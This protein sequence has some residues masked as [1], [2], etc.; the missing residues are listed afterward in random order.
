MSEKVTSTNLGDCP[1]CKA[2]G[3]PLKEVY[4]VPVCDKCSQKMFSEKVRARILEA[5]ERQQEQK[6][7]ELW[8]KRI[9][10]VKKGMKLYAEKKHSEALKYFREYIA[11]LEGHYKIPQGTLHPSIFSKKEAGDI[12]LISGI[13]WDMAKIYDQNNK[14]SEMQAALHKFVEFSMNRPHVILSAEAIRKYIAKDEAK[15]KMA[16]INALTMLRNNMKKCFIATAV[17]G[18][19]SVE[20]SRLRKFRD[21][22]LRPHR[23]GRLGVKTYYFLSPPVAR[24]AVRHP[25]ISAVAQKLLDQFLKFI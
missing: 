19:D 13:Y 22:K 1:A 11:I 6:K 2:K 21:K 14:V 9:E 8:G 25:M 17:Y 16:F 24:M 3:V 4:G 18:P 5:F 12:L 7:K 23:L 10:L 15:N 20:V